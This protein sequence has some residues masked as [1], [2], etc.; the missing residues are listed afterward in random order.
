MRFMLK[1]TENVCL[2]QDEMCLWRFDLKCKT[3]SGC[4]ALNEERIN[5]CIS[6]GCKPS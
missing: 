2:E 5:E 4:Q 3:F 6:V 1:T